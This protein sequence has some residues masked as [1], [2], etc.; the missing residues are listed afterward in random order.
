MC[1]HLR[2]GV[3]PLFSR[4]RTCQDQKEDPL[5]T[6]THTHSAKGESQ[7]KNLNCHTL[8]ISY[9]PTAGLFAGVHCLCRSVLYFLD[10]NINL[11]DWSYISINN[12]GFFLVAK[13]PKQV[14][15]AEILY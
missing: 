10:Y 3:L 7:T 4:E 1:V 6:H 5:T 11:L 9:S 13:N 12:V 8:L 2:P 14:N 15:P